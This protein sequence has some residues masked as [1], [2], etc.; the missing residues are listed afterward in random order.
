MALSSCAWLFCPTMAALTALA[1]K[2]TT[3]AATPAPMA[4]PAVLTPIPVL[5]AARCVSLKARRALF[6]SPLMS[7]SISFLADATGTSVFASAATVL[8]ASRPATLISF[9]RSLSTPLH[10]ATSSLTPFTSISSL[11]TASAP[12]F[13]DLLDAAPSCSLASV[14][15]RTASAPSSTTVLFDEQCDHVGEHLE[16]AELKIERRDAGRHRDRSY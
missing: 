11:A 3:A 5:S 1:P 16:V 6:A 15:R 12:P 9:T 10:A 14:G 8:A 7:T 13:A 2:A 4:R